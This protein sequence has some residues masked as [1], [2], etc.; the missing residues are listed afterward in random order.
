M[1]ANYK[2]FR[3]SAYAVFLAVKEPDRLGLVTKWLYP[4]VADRYASSCGAAERNIR[5]A[6]AVAWKNNP[7]LLSELAGYTLD[8]KP[9]AAQFISILACHVGRGLLKPVPSAAPQS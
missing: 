1:T 8:V 5:T 9:T 3:Q 2:G 7:V 4:A 6:A